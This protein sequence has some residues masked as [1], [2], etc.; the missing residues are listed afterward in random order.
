MSEGKVKPIVSLEEFLDAAGNPIGGYMVYLGCLGCGEM[1]SEA[2]E[3]LEH[4][5]KCRYVKRVIEL[6]GMV[7]NRED[8]DEGNKA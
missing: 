8:R 6:C 5:K 7:V 4:V 2:S 1:F 3:W